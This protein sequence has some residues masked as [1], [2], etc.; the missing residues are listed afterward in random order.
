MKVNIK[1]DTPKEKIHL[2]FHKMYKEKF[3]K[4]VNLQIRKN[5]LAE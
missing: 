1:Q 3:I 4:I 5:E 2:F